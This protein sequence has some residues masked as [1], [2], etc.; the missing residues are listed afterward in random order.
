MSAPPD[1]A[2]LEIREAFGPHPVRVDSDGKGGALRFTYT[3]GDHVL[4]ALKVGQR[5]PRPSAR[6]MVEPGLIPTLGKVHFEGKYDELARSCWPPGSPSVEA[7]RLQVDLCA[8]DVVQAARNAVNAYNALL[9]L[10]AAV[11]LVR[12]RKRR[13]VGR[14]AGTWALL[15]TSVGSPQADL[16]PLLNGWIGEVVGLAEDGPAGEALGPTVH[17]AA[18]Q[19]KSRLVASR[20]EL[21]RM[22]AREVVAKEFDRWARAD[23]PPRSRPPEAK[24]WKWPWTEAKGT[25]V[26]LGLLAMKAF[27]NTAG[28]PGRWEPEGWPDRENFRFLHADPVRR[29]VELGG[30]LV[31]WGHLLETTEPPVG[32][33]HGRRAEPR[34]GLTVQKPLIEIAPRWR[35]YGRAEGPVDPDYLRRILKEAIHEDARML[36]NVLKRVE[37]AAGLV[38]GGEADWRYEPPESRVQILEGL[39][40]LLAAVAVRYELAEGRPFEA[41]PAVGNGGGAP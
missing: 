13:R 29:D 11:V 26:L 28:D 8:R 37:T 23:P 3:G 39:L 21:G 27:V 19:A 16:T 6:G 5:L 7:V 32:G 25:D 41:A 30:L 9:H 20:K 36:L 12:R 33:P 34:P 18:R 10:S 14:L 35:I 2:L 22:V 24:L 38:R 40:P 1:D 15:R 4:S 17:A 31:V